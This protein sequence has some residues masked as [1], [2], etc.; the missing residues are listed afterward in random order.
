MVLH[1]IRNEVEWWKM[2]SG[3]DDHGGVTTKECRAQFAA[4][5]SQ[6]C[7]SLW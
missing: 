4:F 3:L 1:G 7:E 2:E 5:P 6:F